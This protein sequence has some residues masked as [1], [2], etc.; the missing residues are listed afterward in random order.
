MTSGAA[1]AG[2]TDNLPANDLQSGEEAEQRTD[3]WIKQYQDAKSKIEQTRA[4]AEAKARQVADDTASA[5]SKGALAAAAALV[6]GAIAAAIGGLNARRRVVAVAVTR[7]S[8]G[9]A[10]GTR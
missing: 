4:Q 9:Y 10:A 8:S 7:A 2:A 1:N 6:L 5:T 3:A